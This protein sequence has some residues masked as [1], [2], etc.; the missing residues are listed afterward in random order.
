MSENKSTNKFD[1]R[2]IKLELIEEFKN[3]CGYCG[4]K[5]GITDSGN[6]DHYYPKSRFPELEF[7][8]SN[9]VLACNY[10]NRIKSDRSPIDN[11]GKKVILNPREDIFSDHIKE[12]ENGVLTG[13]TELG[14]STIEVLQLN[15]KALV[16]DRINRAILNLGRE[17]DY[18]SIEP[19][20]NNEKSPY[21]KF[22]E[23]IAVIKQLLE[24]KIENDTLQN[25]QNKL[26]YA[27]VIT[28]METYLSDT[29][30]NKA[31]TS[32]EYLRKFVETFHDF[33]NIK[34][35]YAEIFEKYEDVETY[36][37]KSLLDIMYHNIGKVK[38]MYMDT[39]GIEF[40]KDIK[41]IYQAVNI[42][43]DIVH[44]NGQDKNKNEHQIDG[45]QIQKLITDVSAFIDFINNQI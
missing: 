32:K 26:L 43:H 21:E 20:L 36:V 1:F 44:R 12:D 35:D 4:S 30:I 41:S 23:S 39:F 17:E 15:R 2:K 7:Q 16:E 25:H 28:S 34:F 5:I 24:V 38:G 10:C 18:K 13:V 42:R 6:V 45:M 37:T 22:Q 11:S 8:K 29:F 27:N 40:P 31:I 19:I 33:K 9:L 14:N 3:R